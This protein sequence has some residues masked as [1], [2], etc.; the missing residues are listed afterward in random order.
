MSLTL[1]AAVANNGCIGKDGRLP[2]RIPEDLKRF[3]TFTTG[4]IV[5]MGRKTWESIPEKFRPLP[6]RTNIVLTRNPEYDLPP[7][8]ERF[9]D[10]EKALAAHQFEEDVFVIGGADLYAQTMNAADRL[11]ITEVDQA[12][13]GDAFF[14]KIDPEQWMETEREAHDGFAFVTYHRR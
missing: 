2:W 14:P 11:L 13:E 12:I 7:D 8:V 1:I 4:H 9:A 10:L 5:L 6:G 3:K